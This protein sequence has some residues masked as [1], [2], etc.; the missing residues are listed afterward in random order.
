[1][2]ARGAPIEYNA[3]NHGYHYND[4]AYELPSLVITEGD[5]L[6]V[7][8]ADRALS[9][10][11]NSP[12]YGR[13]KSVF[14]RLTDLLPNRV[15]VQSSDL[16]GRMSVI[17][18]PVT[19]IAPQVWSVLHECLGE[20]R[21][22]VLHYR[23]PGYREAAV[24]I[25]DPYHIVAYRGEWYVIGYSHHDEEV[26]IYALSRI[27]SC[28]RHSSSFRR[29]EDFDP[30]A[31][32]DPA[33]GVFLGGPEHEIAVRFDAPVASKIA[34]RQWHP[35]QT[36]EWLDDGGI[37]LRFRSNQ[38]NQTLYWVSQWG[39]NA[40]ILEPAELRARAA[41]WLEGAARRYREA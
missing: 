29:P 24:R 2:C 22:A 18:E 19:E 32:I 34:E 12:F 20:E 17:S 5:L 7:L 3:R 9:S 40:E 16:A 33:F 15:T 26:R 14:E 23:A 27:V 31:Y 6:A 35:N 37:V 13:L 41:A 30:A 38:L 8:V 36:V 39:P 11:R 28:K 4:G 10:Y 1:M 21:A 25:I